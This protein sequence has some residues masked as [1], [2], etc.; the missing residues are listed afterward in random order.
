[1]FF[2]RKTRLDGLFTRPVFSMRLALDEDLKQDVKN[3]FDK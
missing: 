2:D 1:V 3:V